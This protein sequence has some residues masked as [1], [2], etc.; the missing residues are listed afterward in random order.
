MIRRMGWHIVGS[1]KKLSYGDDRKVR[2]GQRLEF[3]KL[4]SEHEPVICLRGMH[5]SPRIEDAIRCWR[6]VFN[7]AG[8]T[9]SRSGFLCRVLVENTNYSNRSSPGDSWCGAKFVGSHR[10]ILGMIPFHEIPYKDGVPDVKKTLEKMRAR[11][12]K[13]RVTSVEVK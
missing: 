1:S 11:N 6:L 9:D 2:V 5:A 12:R 3:S 13:N 10:T 8:D 7:K 4:L